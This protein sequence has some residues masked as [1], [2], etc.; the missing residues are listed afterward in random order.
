MG[1]NLTTDSNWEINDKWVTLIDLTGSDKRKLPDRYLEEEIKYP[2]FNLDSLNIVSDNYLFNNQFEISSSVENQLNSTRENVLREK[3]TLTLINTILEENF[4]FGYVS[5]SE[6]IIREQFKI[7]ALATRNWL[8]E[9]FINHFNDITILIGLLRIIG[10]FEENIIFPQG[11]TI[12]LAALNHKNDEIKELGI[13]AFE[14]W[15]SENSIKVLK[16]IEISPQWLCDYKNQ[17]IA[18][19]EEELCHTL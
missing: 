14:N 18:E 9:L 3:L 11:H 15:S 16:N 5:N 4:E 17:V 8:S 13:R 2:F 19:L 10:R 1:K 6:K 12:A 7:N